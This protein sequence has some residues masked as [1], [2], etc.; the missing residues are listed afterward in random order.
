MA[1]TEGNT[2]VAPD[3]VHAPPH[4]RQG[5]VECIDALRAAL[6]EDGYRAFCRGNAIKY[7]W[8][9]EH[10]GNPRQDAEKAAWY[11]ARLVEAYADDQ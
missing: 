10:K 9:A 11:V 3:M 5:G 4:Y 6:G 7:L 1:G 2:G 8:R